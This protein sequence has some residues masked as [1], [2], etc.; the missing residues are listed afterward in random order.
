MAF[1]YI[2]Q[3]E[4]TRRFYIGSTVDLDRRIA[5]HLRGHSPATRGR[6]PWKLA[7]NEQF[8]TLIEARTRELEIKRWKS[9][10]MIQALVG[11]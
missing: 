5:E 7:Y 8:D 2:L 11:S 6:G 3:S 4:T 10:K 1:V 9:S